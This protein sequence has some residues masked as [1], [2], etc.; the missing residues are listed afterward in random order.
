MINDANNRPSRQN[1]K[2]V[3]ATQALTWLARG[4]RDL[5]HCGTLSIAHGVLVAAFGALP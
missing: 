5:W 3:S 4:W 1:I 2:Q